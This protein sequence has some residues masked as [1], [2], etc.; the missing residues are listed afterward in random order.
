MTDEPDKTDASAGDEPAADSRD[1]AQP[2]TDDKSPSPGGRVERTGTLPAPAHDE[3]AAPT[4]ESQA[5]LTGKA[6]SG[7]SSSGTTMPAAP[8]GESDSQSAP[9]AKPKPAAPPAN[10]TPEEKKARLERT[11][12]EAK[13]KKAAA[14]GTAPPAG[15]GKEATATPQPPGGASPAT[16]DEEKAAKIAAAKA[17]A[18]ALKAAAGDK[19]AVPQPATAG[20]TAGAAG[21]PK[22]PVK[23]KEEG[24]KPT[25]ASEH[26][27][28]KRLRATFADAI[29]E[30]T[31]FLGQLSLRVE[32]A[33]V[34]EICD[35]L[36][37]DAETPFDLLCDLTCVHYPE[38]FDAPFEIVYNLYS[39][40]GNARVRLK[41]AATE[42]EGVESVSSVWPTANWLEREVYDLF[43]VKFA[44]HPDLRRLL[45]PDD[46]DGHPLRK[47]YPL[48]AMENDWSARHLPE[49][50]DVQREQL[51]QRR[52]YGLE[53]LQTPAERRVR[54][55][56]R[57]GKEVMPK[58]HR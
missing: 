46:W 2:R 20:A 23:K 1:R 9:A 48:E 8:S 45:L 17:K 25:D 49:F 39:I 41:V 3:A 36:R 10:E 26:A 32:R 12:A 4:P 14:A 22:A 30:A 27:L 13:A 38:N 19:P 55:I 16:S 31:E 11:I 56:F 52:A 51:E 6:P 21:A 58:E 15:G 34:V 18:A 42:D 40:S 44:N 53:I 57:A 24:P 43:G 50:T 29:T 35:S 47:D 37:R 33:R 5:A 28:V 7:S 54:E